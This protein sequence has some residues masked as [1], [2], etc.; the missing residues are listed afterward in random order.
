MGAQWSAQWFPLSESKNTR[1]P[2]IFLKVQITKNTKLPMTFVE[3]LTTL[4]S[5]KLFQSY[6]SYTFSKGS[7][8]RRSHN[9]YW[10]NSGGTE[11]AH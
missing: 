11:N 3:K 9:G 5:W 6:F 4:V 2:P 8:L 1:A 7:E 10:D